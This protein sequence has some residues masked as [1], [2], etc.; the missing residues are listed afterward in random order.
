MSYICILDTRPPSISSKEGQSVLKYS[1]YE[2]LYK[3]AKQQWKIKPVGSVACTHNLPYSHKAAI[4]L[5]KHNSFVLLCLSPHLQRTYIL[6]SFSTILV[7]VSL[8][9]WFIFFTI[10]MRSTT[11]DTWVLFGSEYF[12]PSHFVQP[13]SCS[14]QLADWKTIQP[15][16]RIAIST[17]YSA[18][19]YKT[20]TDTP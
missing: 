20:I 4:T 11:E 2:K 10:C 15:K 17:V 8:V 5:C 1:P 6:S 14:N 18:S 12:S 9:Y 19:S 3:A 7:L 16:F 13:T